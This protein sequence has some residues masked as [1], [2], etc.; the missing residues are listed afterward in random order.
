VGKPREQWTAEDYRAATEEARRESRF[1]HAEARIR[2]IAEAEP[3]LTPEQRDRL[4]AL[5]LHSGAA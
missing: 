2:R 4:A 3:P 5:L 1:R